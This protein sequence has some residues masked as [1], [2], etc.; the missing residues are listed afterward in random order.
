ME[1]ARVLVGRFWLATILQ[2]GL[3][4]C[5]DIRA[6]RASFALL[7]AGTL[8]LLYSLVLYRSPHW[9]SYLPDCSVPLLD[10]A[11]YL[12]GLVSLLLAYRVFRAIRPK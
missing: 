5:L 6:R 12:L 11:Q 8:L 9:G 1:A 10:L 4:A 7:T 3:I 2:G